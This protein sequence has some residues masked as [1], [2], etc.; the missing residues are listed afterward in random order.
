MEMQ[1]GAC[2]I[3]DLNIIDFKGGGPFSK[4]KLFTDS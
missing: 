4:A 3:M 1:T 2:N